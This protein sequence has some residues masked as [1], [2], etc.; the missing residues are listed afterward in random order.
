[1][2]VQARTRRGSC[3]RGARPP[4]APLALIGNV[5]TLALALACTPSKPPE[6]APEATAIETCQAARGGEFRS[7]KCSYPM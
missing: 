4:A 7:R 2:N 3:S 5:A 6:S 1:M